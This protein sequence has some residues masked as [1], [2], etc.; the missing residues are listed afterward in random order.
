[1]FHPRCPV[2]TAI[3]E[4]DPRLQLCRRHELEALD[5]GGHGGR[6][7]VSCH[8]ATGTTPASADPVPPTVH[9]Q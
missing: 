4:S 6:S 5:D 3:D 2:A 1:R 9:H 7:L 8:L